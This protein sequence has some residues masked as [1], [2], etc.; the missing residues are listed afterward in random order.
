VRE[1]LDR[2]IHVPFQFDYSGSTIIFFD[3]ETD[4]SAEELIR[5]QQHIR[6]FCEAP[7]TEVSGPTVRPGV[8]EC[9]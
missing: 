2:L 3:H 7:H 1:R 4:Y 8:K 6:A 9:A 5:A